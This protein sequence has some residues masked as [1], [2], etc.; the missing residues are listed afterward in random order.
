MRNGIANLCPSDLRKFYKRLRINL[1]RAE[2]DDKVSHYSI[3]EYGSITERPHYHAILFGIGSEDKALIHETWGHG[4]VDIGTVTPDSIRYVA[5]YID[6]KLLGTASYFSDRENSF[7]VCSQGIG[8]DWIRGELERVLYDASLKFRGKQFP[9]P[10]RYREE[11]ARMFPAAAEGLEDRIFASALDAEFEMIWNLAP[12]FGGL[13][14]SELSEHQKIELS[15][16][17]HSQGDV[18]EADILA[19]IKFKENRSKL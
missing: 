1:R 17:I 7:Q 15:K 5:Q 9:L 13:Q 10:R 12:E 2:R 8:V 4:H 19:G 6:K 11:I 18:N 3:G 14:Y 16:R